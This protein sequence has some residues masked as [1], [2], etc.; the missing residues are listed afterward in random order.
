[1]IVGIDFVF[2][3]KRQFNN[4]YCW[5]MLLLVCTSKLGTIVDIKYHPLLVPRFQCP[6]HS[7]PLKN[8][9]HLVNNV[10][11]TRDFSTIYL[12]SKQSLSPINMKQFYIYHIHETK[13]RFIK[14]LQK[15]FLHKF[16]ISIP[17]T[18]IWMKQ[19]KEELI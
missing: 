7:P 3:K 2:H 18:N 15:L 8:S 16:S 10:F 5:F 14:K 11:N 17:Y 13:E 4:V 1:M 12:S 9:R 19:V 6:L